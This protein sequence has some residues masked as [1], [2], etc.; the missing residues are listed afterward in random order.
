MQATGKIVYTSSY[1]LLCEGALVTSE[2]HNDIIAVNCC[3]CNNAGMQTTISIHNLELLLGH[4]G[5]YSRQT[6]LG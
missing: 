5:I 1:H 2:E 3:I 6:T 4:K